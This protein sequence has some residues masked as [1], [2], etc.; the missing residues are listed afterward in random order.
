METGNHRQVKR[1]DLVAFGPFDLEPGASAVITREFHDRFEVQH[2]VHHGG[3][4]AGLFLTGL[5]VAGRRRVDEDG[6]GIPFS[7]FAPEINGKKLEPVRAEKGEA[8]DLMFCNRSQ[9]K[10]RA[11]AVL[12]GQAGGV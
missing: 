5:R 2:I 11:V 1:A 12:L 10:K 8:I 9:A 7:E 6:D 4:V 3:D